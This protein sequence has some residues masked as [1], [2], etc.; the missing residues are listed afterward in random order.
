MRGIS[1]YTEKHTRPSQNTKHFE[2]FSFA[3][4]R[5]VLTFAHN[6]H[7]T[8][9]SNRRN[10][11]GL[12]LLLLWT[13]NSPSLVA[14]AAETEETA[15]ASSNDAA[16]SNDVFLESPPPLTSENS[17][18]TEPSSTSQ[19]PVAS[20]PDLPATAAAEQQQ[21]EAQAADEDEEK[22]KA[23]PSRRGRIRELEDIRSELAEKELVLLQKEQELL[24][25]DQTLM[26]LREELEIE[27]KLRAL[28]TKEREKA[29]EE[30]ALA[31][32]I[33]GGGSMLP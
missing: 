32:G 17:S 15:A 12:S 27:K 29:E 6:E 14:N 30:A 3:K 26:V 28:I 31:M 25:K 21:V 16:P 22:K 24:D 33:C 19:V 1:L 8:L 23:K 18:V 10:L 4:R 13:V 7:Y 9:I 11:L 2:R 20:D 5:C